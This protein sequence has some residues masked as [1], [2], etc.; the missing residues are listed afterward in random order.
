MNEEM[1]EIAETMFDARRKMNCNGNCKDCEYD[2]EQIECSCN[3]KVE[4]EALYNA[5]YRKINQTYKQLQEE[6]ARLHERK[7][8]L[9]SFIVEKGWYEYVGEETPKTVWHKVADGDLPKENMEVCCF[10]KNGNYDVG[11]L[12]SAWGKHKWDL[13]RVNVF[14]ELNDV[15]AWTELPKYEGEE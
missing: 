8:Y 13:N 1:K 10:Y 12:I 2:K 9:E 6:N 11:K 3:E 15:I 7:D 5:G 14:V 4:A